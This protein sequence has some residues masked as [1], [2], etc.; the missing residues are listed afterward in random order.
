MKLDYQN[1]IFG[2]DI[3]RATAIL[4]VVCSHVLWVFPEL[5]NSFTEILRFFGVMGVEIFFVLSGFLIGRILF[6]I[7]TSNDFGFNH[8]FYFLIRRWFRTF[9]NYY[10]VLLINILIVLF[11][12]RSLPESLGYY[13]FFLQNT[14]NGMDIFFTES[15]SLP[16]EEFAYIIGQILF[17]LVFSL[18]SKMNRKRSF[19]I[20]TLGIITFFLLSKVYYN[21]NTDSNSMEIWNIDLKA[22]VLYRIDAIYYGVLAAYLSQVKPGFWN[23]N[24]GYLFFIGMIAFFGMHVFI[25]AYGYT[26]QNV[27][28]FWNVLYLPLCSLCIACSLPFFSNLNNAPGFILKPFTFISVISYSMYLLHYS[29]ILQLLNFIMPSGALSLIQKLLFSTGY[30]VSTIFL[31]YLLYRWYEKPM[32]DIIDLPFI[33][34][35]L[36]N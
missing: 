14:V 1:R 9:P 12:G 33:R 35:K 26:I 2:L 4:F 8:F 32:M 24:K 16:I 5:E 19:M 3:M 36:S 15:W 25:T 17:Y 11:I 6:R 20:I 30:M 13:F 22:V 18:N 34:K 31:S 7:Y 29:I 23:K 28:F 10:L 21:I 27:P